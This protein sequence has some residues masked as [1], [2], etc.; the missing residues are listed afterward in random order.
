M[1]FKINH[2]FTPA[3]GRFD[4]WSFSES[5]A[6]SLIESRPLDVLKANRK[7]FMR[8]YPGSLRVSS[9]NFNPVFF[10][11]SGCQMGEF[12]GIFVMLVEGLSL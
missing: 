6:Q 3:T 2:T 12:W 11:N 9:S 7:R 8:V 1:D 10:W 5:R 4:V